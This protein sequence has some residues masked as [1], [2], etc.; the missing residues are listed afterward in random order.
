MYI[1]NE[2]KL[3]QTLQ[4]KLFYDEQEQNKEITIAEG[5][6]VTI[7]YLKD[8]SIATITGKVVKI[9]SELSKCTHSNLNFIRIDISDK[10]ASNTKDIFIA[11][12]RDIYLGEPVA[13]EPEEPIEEPNNP[14]TPIDNSEDDIEEPEM[15]IIEPEEPIDESEVPEEETTPEGGV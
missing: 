6:I 13:E 8:T 5:D 14:E 7:S 4:I 9:V 10:Y 11:N 12:I 15:P 3:I 1:T 2:V